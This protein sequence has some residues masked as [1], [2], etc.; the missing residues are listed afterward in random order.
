MYI[1]VSQLPIDS[2]NS[3]SFLPK[4]VLEHDLDR[5]SKLRTCKLLFVHQQWLN[6][7]RVIES[8]SDFIDMHL[9][10]M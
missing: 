5:V 8:Y 4:F 3:V 9:D 1:H 10:C 2:P 6:T 7:E